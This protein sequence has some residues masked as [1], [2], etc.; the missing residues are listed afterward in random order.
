MPG[1]DLRFH[2]ARQKRF[3]EDQTKFFVVCILSALEF[4][5]SKGFLHRDVKPEN[6]VLDTF[7]YAYLTD[8]GVARLWTS[9]NQKDTSGT[10]GYM[11]PEVM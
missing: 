6:I 5:H 9:D 11:A 4:I 10:P 3:R 2:L 1:G 8:F 7:G